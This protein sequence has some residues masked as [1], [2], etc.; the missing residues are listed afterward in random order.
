MF[1]TS[2]GLVGIVALF[3]QAQSDFFSHGLGDF[4][5]S[6]EVTK[7]Y[8]S[9]LFERILIV[10]YSSDPY[11]VSSFGNPLHFCIRNRSSSPHSHFPSGPNISSEFGFCRGNV[12]RGG[13][14]IH[15]YCCVST[16][17]ISGCRAGVF[18]PYPHVGSTFRNGH[19]ASPNVNV[20]PQLPRGGRLHGLNCCV[21]G[22]CCTLGMVKSAINQPYA[23]ASNEHFQKGDQKQ[24]GRPPRYIFLGLGI[25]LVCAGWLLI[26]RC[27]QR[28]GD[29]MDVV[30][31]GYRDAWWRV[32]GW[33]GLALLSGG[34]AA[35]ALTYGLSLYA[36]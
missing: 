36:P 24:P 26:V 20:S 9:G 11:Y 33:L 23:S 34:L 25:A 5:A 35:G 14:S 22:I 1:K 3:A 27:F 8:V 16:G 15:P 2:L 21:G 13:E 19:G 29:A 30:L 18:Q 4:I 12:L 7:V 10:K 17:F 32:G 31:D 28:A 6:K